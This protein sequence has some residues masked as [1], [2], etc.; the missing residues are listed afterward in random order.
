MA[1]K[2]GFITLAVYYHTHSDDD[3]LMVRGIT[4]L[5]DFVKWVESKRR[6]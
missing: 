2:R 4:A 5:D 6:K 3:W 1:T